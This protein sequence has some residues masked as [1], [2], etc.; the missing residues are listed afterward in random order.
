MF[1]LR[2]QSNILN[3]QP[4]VFIIIIYSRHVET[5]KK[6]NNL[7]AEASNLIKHALEQLH[8]STGISGTRGESPGQ[9]DPRVELQL[10]GESIIYR[11]E[12]K[13]KLDRF[14]AL[15]ALK[16]KTFDDQTSLLVTNRISPEMAAR[17]RK[18]DMQFIDTAGNAY[19][20]NRH[21][22]FVFVSG[23]RE[24]THVGLSG[25][26]SVSTP[27]ALRVA[28][29]LLAQPR[30]LNATYREIAE[31]SNVSLG[32]VGQVFTSLQSRG[33]IGRDGAGKRAFLHRHHLVVDWTAGYINR[34]KPKLQKRRFAVPN[35]GDLM[36][37]VP[38][39]GVSAWG[40]E[41]A[42]AMLTGNL[43]PDTFTI[44]VDKE[45]ATPLA[46][47]V[48]K[49]RLKADPNGQLEI[50]ESFWDA[51]S[52]GVGLTVPPELI[53]ADL[54]ATLDSRNIETAKFILDKVIANA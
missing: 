54:M 20:N 9:D 33:F 52:L 36:Q 10:P 40:G 37:W 18:L 35:P 31:T 26:Y 42:A 41:V 39:S 50:V 17:C 47:L 6:M 15:Q 14:S 27:A 16:A 5:E 38:Q 46:E 44:Y 48:S 28:F 7:R 25:D 53:Y 13:F 51:K 32:L 49:Y 8:A 22:L 19:L 45:L 1:T 21:G 29:A 24:S 23:R 34:L 30:L 4:S 2:E 12:V 3:K 11:S 43:K